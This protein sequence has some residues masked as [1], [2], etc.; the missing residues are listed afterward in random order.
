MADTYRANRC[1]GPRPVRSYERGCGVRVYLDNC[2]Y[3]RP[4]DNHGN[5]V[6]ALEALAKLQIQAMMHEGKIEYVWSD[7]LTC[8]VAENPFL[9]RRESILSWAGNAVA[10]VRSTNEVL[11]RGREL[12]KLGLK[13]KDALHVASAEIAHCDWLI[14]TDRGLTKKIQ[15]L[16]DMT[17]GNPMSF[18]TQEASYE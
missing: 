6:V 5:M 13:A 9:E 12:Q 11:E 4:F 17:I 8:E 15:T 10:Y 3:N 2:C 7:I 14:T 18:I 1:D 16:G